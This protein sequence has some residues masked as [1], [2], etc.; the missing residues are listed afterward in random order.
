MNE[1]SNYQQLRAHLAFLR[2]TA[3]AAALP[4]E[5]DHA[6]SDD[7]PLA[8]RVTDH[9]EKRQG[10][11]GAGDELRVDGQQQQAC[12]NGH[13]W[14]VEMRPSQHLPRQGNQT[15]HGANGDE[16]GP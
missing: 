12:G 3:A 13:E 4:A 8:G 9:A 15:G 10:R 1:R 2:M 14:T 16:R 7:A 11:S 5:L 6:R